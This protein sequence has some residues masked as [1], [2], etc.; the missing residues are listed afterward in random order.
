MGYSVTRVAASGIIAGVEDGD[1][2][3]KPP[4]SMGIGE[5]QGGK[6]ASYWPGLQA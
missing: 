1:T 4:N 5:P 6:S 2:G 3:Q